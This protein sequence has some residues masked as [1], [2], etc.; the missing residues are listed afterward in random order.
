MDSK[1]ILV[2]GNPGSGKSS[3][4]QFINDQLRRN[5]I[6]SRWYHEQELPHPVAP[7][8]YIDDFSSL[9][10]YFKY[11]LDR[12][13]LF[14]LTAS[15]SDK[16][17]IIE[18]RFFQDVIFPLLMRDVSRSQIIEYVHGIA[19]ICSSLNP[20]LIYFHQPEYA[21]TMRRICDERGP[22]TEKFYI[23]RNDQSAYARRLGLRG[24]DGYVQFF[25][26]VRSIMEQLYEELPFIKLS[27]DNT[28]RKWGRYYKQIGEFLPIP[29]LFNNAPSGQD[30]LSKFEGTYTYQNDEKNIEF[31]IGL[32]DDELLMHNY[33]W[34]WRINRLI[35]KEENVFHLGGYPF[36][37]IFETDPNGIVIGATRI[38][39]TGDWLVT[40]QRYPGINRCSPRFVNEGT[41]TPYRATHNKALQSDAAKPRR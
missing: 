9:G 40:G 25:V 15:E 7:N 13:H 29:Q 41:K 14:S 2:E 30:Y 8:K 33:G 10:E 35:P 26:A 36:E 21:T 32:K 28:E 12:W 34:L 5:G 19:D 37:L 4:S 24:F 16:I 6:T 38:N 22:G 18:S 3:T 11:A 31:S 27:I 1:L 17:S 20:K 39:P 23:D